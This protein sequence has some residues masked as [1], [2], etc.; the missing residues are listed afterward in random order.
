MIWAPLTTTATA[1][2]NFIFKKQLAKWI[3][4]GSFAK[5]CFCYCHTLSLLRLLL[6]LFNGI[7]PH[8]TILID[9]SFIPFA[10]HFICS[11]FAN[12]CKS[13]E[14]RIFVIWSQSSYNKNNQN[15]QIACTSPDSKLRFCSY[16]IWF[17]DYIANDAICI[18]L[19]CLS[20]ER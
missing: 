16:P 5:R 10:L 6:L 3:N 11:L 18:L 15:D 17:I 1:E 9:N 7:I 19:H 4:C 2:S 12:F 8:Y 14:F 20:N 13:N